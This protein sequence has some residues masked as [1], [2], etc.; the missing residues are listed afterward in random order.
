MNELF[1]QKIKEKLNP[2]IDKISINNFENRI[3]EKLPADYYIFLTQIC[4]G[5]ADDSNGGI[6]NFKKAIE[7]CH[8]FY[9]EDYI[10]NISFDD[11]F[12]EFP[13]KTKDAEKY[14]IDVEEFNNY[15]TP[16]FTI[17]NIS[18]VLYLSHEGMDNY[19]IL[20]IKGE[21]KGT[22]WFLNTQL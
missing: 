9:S 19:Y 22:I 16:A 20:V 5:Y 12:Y 4:D 11:C 13:I 3:N 14:I 15:Y 1:L 8:L 6:F 17:K 2:P 18:G 10:E 7:Y 21:Q